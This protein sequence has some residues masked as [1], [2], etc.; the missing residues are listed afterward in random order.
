MLV[1]E[2][3]SVEGLDESIFGLLTIILYVLGVLLYVC[4]EVILHE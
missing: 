1:W 3:R 2:L 4:V